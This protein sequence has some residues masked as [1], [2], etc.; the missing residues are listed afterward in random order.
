MYMKYNGCSEK[1]QIKRLTMIL[2]SP[3]NQSL[4]QSIVKYMNLSELSSQLPY[5][6]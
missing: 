2:M 3:L 4:P 5:A 6:N 1:A